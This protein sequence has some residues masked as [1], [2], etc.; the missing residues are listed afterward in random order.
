MKTALINKPSL[1][2]IF[3]NIAFLRLFAT[4]SYYYPLLPSNNIDDPFQYQYGDQYGAGLD[5]SDYSFV[6]IPY[7]FS[8]APALPVVPPGHSHSYM[9][10][11]PYS[12]LDQQQGPIAPDSPV[13]DASSFWIDPVF[14]ADAP[15]QPTYV[16]EPIISPRN[17]FRSNQPEVIPLGMGGG[18]VGGSR[19]RKPFLPRARSAANQRSQNVRLVAS[20]QKSMMPNAQM[21]MM[22]LMAPPQPQPMQQPPPLVAPSPV[23]SSHSCP[24]G[25]TCCGDTKHFDP[26]G[27]LN[28]RN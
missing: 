28:V 21:Q 8:G 24:Q 27:Q 16:V 12:I 25:Y 22:D 4:A 20:Q 14:D 11:E 1:I 19:R 23:D 17:R 2:N 13:F 26:Q 10:V 3:A 7:D 18:G 9:D 6:A 15:N 5:D